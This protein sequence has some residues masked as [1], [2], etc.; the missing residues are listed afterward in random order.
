MS[1]TQRDIIEAE[2]RGVLA[3]MAG[4]I[5]AVSEG[6]GSLTRLAM[7]QLEAEVRH[8]LERFIRLIDQLP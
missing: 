1:P 6:T 3:E 4:A 8:G 5:R 7:R 2:I